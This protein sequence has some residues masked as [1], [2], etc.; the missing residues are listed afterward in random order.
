MSEL[1]RAYFY[2][3]ERDRDKAIDL[4]G[5]AEV[6][7]SEFVRVALSEKMNREVLVA[8]VTKV[9]EEL[10]E[11]VLEMRTEIARTRKDLM[12]DNQRGMELVRQDIARSMKKNEELAKA[13]VMQ[14][15]GI[16]PRS[17]KHAKPSK[18]SDD[19]P[20]PVPG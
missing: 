2:I 11:L 10:S 12:D 1:K 3:S 9:R 19:S 7:F 17:D 13:F 16:E 6:S 4:A 15:A 20:M 14:L 8:Q 5:E 18:H